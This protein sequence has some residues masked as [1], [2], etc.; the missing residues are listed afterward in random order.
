MT[1]V[2][3]AEISILLVAYFCHTAT[4]AQ[5]QQLDDWI[6]A[7]DDHMRVFDACL[8]ALLTAKVVDPERDEGL[9]P[10]QHDEHF[11]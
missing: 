9:N 2:V 10:S 3:P 11:D 6:C 1:A 8:E 4:E 5:P 7:S